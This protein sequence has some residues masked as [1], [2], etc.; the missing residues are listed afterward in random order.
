M[1]NTSKLVID[2]VKLPLYP[3]NHERM[4][5]YSIGGRTPH[6]NCVTGQ[7]LTFWLLNLTE[8]GP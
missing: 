4:K 6:V 5:M 2:K 8:S 1:L 7:L 3:K